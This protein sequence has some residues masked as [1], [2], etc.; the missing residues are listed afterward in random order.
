MPNLLKIWTSKIRNFERVSVLAILLGMAVIAAAGFLAAKIVKKQDEA[1]YY[2]N[3]KNLS[4]Q[5]YS[6]NGKVIEINLPQIKLE[7]G[8]VVV[9]DKG[10]E[11]VNKTYIATID[12]N[13]GY[14]TRTEQ[15][16]FQPG[17]INDL[18]V[19]SVITVHSKQNPFEKNTFTATKVEVN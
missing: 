6:L 17:T 12:E 4:V 8:Q 19:G 2:N 13:T 14:Y 1:V 18:T 3:V 7:V 15:Q 9:T 16:T 11:L 10:N 5:D